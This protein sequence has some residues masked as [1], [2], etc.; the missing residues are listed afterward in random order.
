VEFTGSPIRA[1]EAK[2]E[3][4]KTFRLSFGRRKGSD[5]RWVVEKHFGKIEAG[6]RHS[7]YVRNLLCNISFCLFFS[8]QSKLLY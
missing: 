6:E 2:K 3:K 5:C 4:G 8:L 7:Y 1:K